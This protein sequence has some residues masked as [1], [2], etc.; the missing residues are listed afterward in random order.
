MKFFFMNKKGYTTESGGRQN[1]FAIEPEINPITEKE[2]KR[3]LEAVQNLRNLKN[4]KLDQLNISIIHKGKKTK[5]R[6]TKIQTNPQMACEMH[7][8]VVVIRIPEAKNAQV[9]DETQNSM[10]LQKRENGELNGPRSGNSRP[11]GPKG[12]L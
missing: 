2:S 8:I 7:I 10:G 3:F 12:R 5:K 9:M 4:N 1:G 11:N 6:A